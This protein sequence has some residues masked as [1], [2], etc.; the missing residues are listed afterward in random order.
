MAAYGQAQPARPVLLHSGEAYF[1]ENVQSFLRDPGFAAEVPVQGYYYRLIQFSSQPSAAEQQALAAAGLQLMDY[2]PY[3]TWLAAIPGQFPLQLLAAKGVRS[4]MPFTPQMR[5]HQQLYRGDIP[6][7]A[8][9]AGDLALVVQLMPQAPMAAVSGALARS[10]VKITRSVGRE[11]LLELQIAPGELMSLAAMPFV[12]WIEARPAPPEPDDT[13]GRSLHR[14][15]LLISGSR[16]YD[17]TGVSVAVRDDGQLG[18]HIDFQG[19]LDQ[20]FASPSNGTHGDGVGGIFA[21]AGNYNSENRGMAPGAF[22]YAMDYQADFLDSTLYLHTQ[23]GM[24]VTNSSYSNGCNTGYTTIARR[25]DQQAYDYPSLLHVFSAGN[26][27][28]SSCGYGAGTQWGNIT[29]GHKMGKN[30]IATANLFADDAL[31]SSSSRGPANDGRIKPD[32]A[33]NGQNQIS[34]DPNN[35]YQSFGGTSGAAPGIAGISAQLYQAYRQLNGGQDP[36]TPLIKAA[37]LNTAY[38]LG[39]RGPD[40]KYGWGRVDAYRAALLLEQNR[41]LSNSVAQGIT[42][43]HTINV[44]AGVKEVRFMLYWL[45]P[46]GTVLSS[47]ALVNDLNLSATSPSAQPLL[48]W[49]L[50]PAPN[51]TT[52][53]APATTGVDNLNNVEQIAL[54]DPEPG[55]YV[56]QVS[57][58]DVP[59]GPQK[60]YLLHEF[61]YDE[62]LVVYPAGG[63]SLVPSTVE[64][65]RWDAPGPFGTSGSFTVEYSLDDGQTWTV[66]SATVP[67]AA[68]FYDWNPPVA[69]TG[70]ARVRVSR[71][72]VSAQSGRFS[73][74]RSPSGLQVERVCPD[75]TRLTWTAA[76]GATGYE[77]FQLGALYMDS[78]AQS[79][80][81]SVDVYGTNLSS[82][83]WFAIRSTGPDSARGRRTLPTLRAPGRF[84]CPIA[85]DVAVAAP[86][87]A[88]SLPLQDCRNNN[89]QISV[90]LK[91]ESASAIS[92]VQVFY[93]FGANAPSSATYSGTLAPGFSAPFT[94][95]GNIAL[96]AAGDYPVKI[97]AVYPGDT[98]NYNDTVDSFVRVYPG[99]TV[100]LPFVEDFEGQSLCSTASDCGTTDCVLSGGWLNMPN[101]QGDGIDWRVN[102]GATPSDSTGPDADQKPGTSAGKYLYL[103]ASGGCFQQE[104]WL[105]SPCFDLSNAAEPQLSFWYHASGSNM[106]RLFVDINL[107]G[108]WVT[109]FFPPIQGNQGPGWKQA[110]LDLT[111]FGGSLITLRFRG[112][113]GNGVFSDLAIDH[114]A[115]YDR[116]APP[117]ADFI[118]DR[119]IVCPGQTVNFQNF[120]VNTPSQWLWE[121]QPAGMSFLTGSSDSSAAPQVQ[122]A[123]EGWYEIRLSASNAYG[124]S[125]KQRSA[126]IRVD[127]GQA[128]DIVEGFEAGIPPQDWQIINP[129][130]SFGWEAAQVTGSSGQPTTALFMNNYDYPTVGARD[131]VQTFHVNLDGA[132]QPKLYFDVAYARYNANFSDTLEVYVSSDC[133]E[134]FALPIYRRGGSNLASV[135]DDTEFFEPTLASQWRTDSLD[136]S[137]LA[138]STAVIRFVNINDYGNALYLDNIRVR[139]RGQGSPVADFEAFAAPVC[140]NSDQV[141]TYSG[142]GPAPDTISWDFGADALPA[143]ATGPGPHLVRWQSPGTK[144]V[145]VSASNAVGQTSRLKAVYVAP[146]P[147][148]AFSY[149]DSGLSVAFASTSTGAT[150]FLWDFGDGSSSADSALTHLFPA[151]GIYDVSLIARNEYCA[152]TLSQRLFLAAVS[153]QPDLAGAFIRLSPNPAEDWLRIEVSGSLPQ[154]WSYRLLDLQG[155][156][157]LSATPGRTAAWS[158]DLPLAKLT[159]GIYLLQIQAGTESRMY[160]VVKQ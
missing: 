144:L 81:T 89:V 40:F 74:L 85:N 4:V 93:Q 79:G 99:N 116:L 153:L 97:W 61:V 114:I 104:A 66:L 63:E 136:L 95:P 54:L 142:S 39:N 77:A 17:G 105:V 129:D 3:Q 133:G 98:V 92:G 117:V 67:S 29:G 72:G 123:A 145:Q 7:H 130:G 155:R 118:A 16:K 75:Y 120:T 34:T 151:S 10:G 35:G 28:G 149:A 147:A 26:S 132:A 73:I 62:I 24:M 160:R 131:F 138:G 91:N 134:N 70:K 126:Y 22:I 59:Q 37:M 48:P 2:I 137:S 124:T 82:E 51:P 148:A 38:D 135:P 12:K 57:G 68:R 110:S 50:N 33:A 20:T 13:R 109:S 6:D 121:S 78:V 64:R 60:Y 139:E 113:T 53:D 52:L 55:D 94:F 87:V 43:S 32:I 141:L 159:R 30:V 146:S 31:V 5:V 47:R 18:P 102:S 127:A 115:V 21:G 112:E 23:K 46:A 76:N 15:N 27:N 119:L 44:P 49:L 84:N 69:S 86:G 100:T 56:L 111:P 107:N 11:Q 108:V 122:F 14:S 158:E 58:F 143:S 90:Q 71:G 128:P 1:P 140:T 156:S 9:E 106:G 42:K 45:D 8:W 80:G 96:S 25:V 88:G 41:Y 157:L 36:E 152:D 103:E 83:Y 101:G 125:Q 19:R 154:D 150:S 65:I